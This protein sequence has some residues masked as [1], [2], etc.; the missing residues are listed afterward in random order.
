MDGEDDYRKQYDSVMSDGTHD[1]EPYA[2]DDDGVSSYSKALADVLGSDEEPEAGPAEERDKESQANGDHHDEADDEVSEMGNGMHRAGDHSFATEA[3]SS[4]S[5][6]SLR[7][8]RPWQFPT[9]RRLRS[10]RPDIADSL[11]DSPGQGMSHSP[12][13]LSDDGSARL[14][15]MLP[16]FGEA[17]GNGKASAANGTPSHDSFGKD[18]DHEVLNRSF[19]RL[20]RVC[21]L[22]NQEGSPTVMAVAGGILAVGTHEGKVGLFD[23]SKG[24]IGAISVEG[25]ITAVAF[26]SDKTFL[27]LGTSLGHIF[28]YDVRKISGPAR[29]VP[30]V[31]PHSVAQGRSEGHLQGSKILHLGFVGIRHTAIVSAD[32]FGLSFYHSLG[33]ILGVS[34]ND[35]LRILGRY[36]DL[37]D[38]SRTRKLIILGMATL[39]L[40]SVQHSSDANNFVALLTPSKMVLVGLK[41][42]ARTWY[43]H[44]TPDKDREAIA[45]CL[46]WIPCTIASLPSSITSS[47]GMIQPTL[48]FSFGRHLRFLKLV[49]L[50]ENSSVSIVEERRW[51]WKHTEV[52]EAIQ[53]LSPEF[54]VISSNSKLSLYDVRVGKCTEEQ[55]IMKLASNTWAEQKIEGRTVMPTS[56]GSLKSNKNILF[57]LT[58]KEV[59]ASNLVSW[60]DR[61]L[62][63]V[64]TGNFLGAIELTTSLLQEGGATGGSRVGLPEAFVDQKPILR[65]RLVEL[66]RASTSYVFSE[67]RMKDD[68]ADQR[69]GVDRTPL[70]EGLARVCA[71]ASLALDDSSFLFEELFDVYSET[72][73]EAIFADQMEDFIVGGQMKV[74]PIPVVQ[75]LITVRT[76]QKRFDLAERIIWN[77][78]PTCLDLDQAISLCLEQGLY[79]AVI[80]IYTKSLHDFVGP[81]VE[82][83]PL[84]KTR[85]GDAYRI[86][87]YL[88]IS[89]VGLTYPNREKLEEQEADSA[90]SSLYSFIF[91]GRCIIWPPGAGG[92]LI[93]TKDDE[94]GSSEPTFPYLTLLLQFD[95]EALLDA[96]DN[97]FEDSWLDEGDMTRQDIVSILFELLDAPGAGQIFVAIFI[98]RNAPKFP[99]F[100]QLGVEQVEKLLVTLSVVV[101]GDREGADGG[102]EEEQGTLEDRQF[103]LEC[104]LSAYKP[105]HTSAMLQQFERAG[106]YDILRR[107]YRME[108]KWDKLAQMIVTSPGLSDATLDDV[109]DVLRK[110]KKDAKVQN[111]V[112]HALPSLIDVDVK[113]CV[114]MVQR[115]FPAKELEAIQQLDRSP[116]RQLAYVRAFIDLP[117]KQAVGVHDDIRDLY[118]SLICSLEPNLLVSSLDERGADYF[119]LHHVVEVTREEGVMDGFLW[120]KDRLGQTHDGLLEV[121]QFITERK[122]ILRAS[123]EADVSVSLDPREEEELQEAKEQIRVV[124][125]MA[126][127]ICTERVQEELWIDVLKIV[128]QLTHD[129][130]DCSGF[131]FSRSL[132]EDTLSSFVS[133]TSAESVS[134]STLFQKLV[135]DQEGS[136][137]AE[138]RIITDGMMAANKL[139]QELL[140]ITNRL[141]DR[142]VYSE[143]VELTQKQRIGWRPASLN[144]V[145][146]YC[147]MSCIGEKRLV[148]LAK[149]KA[150]KTKGRKSGKEVVKNSPSYLETP[151]HPRLDKGKGVVRG[152]HNGTNGLSHQE[153]D[154]FAAVR[155]SHSTDPIDVFSATPAVPDEAR[156]V[157]HPGI[158][159]SMTAKEEDSS[160][161]DDDSE[162]NEEAGQDERLLVFKSGEIWHRRCAP[163]HML[164]EQ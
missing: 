31:A 58:S 67:D 16:P 163:D 112:L 126:I 29:H 104:L 64:S 20:S 122:L 152:D 85:D 127:R 88:S 148:T 81:I 96:L 130:R 141:F 79:D 129:T 162:E 7:P 46:A 116:H 37:T 140:S 72:G 43:R 59:I 2:I 146:H 136:T 39:P 6:L 91:S 75:R 24:W 144:S 15:W 35:T 33:K 17:G 113:R 142:D 94:E 11:I 23:R 65:S 111:I 49:S 47:T 86:M 82:V 114:T 28:L 155:S 13:I 40:G 14:G 69:G 90:R 93:L 34:S 71:Q 156:Y 97:A 68:M 42:T 101:D 74:L 38:E 131:S 48:A 145:C 149:R 36:P 62:A 89:L 110:S 56:V 60:A 160:D 92:K 18:V 9:P 44:I 87:S 106:F 98:A 70:F 100:I 53:W 12:S 25:S 133:S 154:Y 138:V 137:Y 107:V 22:N 108:G 83:I 32:E 80:H 118:I 125:E 132:L 55:T 120:A 121:D 61:I 8:I 4:I 51:S 164:Q 45:G 159:K 78:D 27:A 119:D 158:N 105:P 128:I 95:A 50:K 135:S 52:I 63:L 99:Q 151:V 3:G 161:G 143:L 139:R 1:V 10:L 103:A 150:K 76:K 115:Y 84:I 117:R 73:I 157:G 41:P 147:G 26:S 124:V 134:F 30:P 153:D 123:T 66:M 19:L 77:V 109:I 21:T 102:V 5:S 54:L 57:L